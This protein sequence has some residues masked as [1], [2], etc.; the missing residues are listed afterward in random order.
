MARSVKVQ[1]EKKIERAPDGTW[2]GRGPPAD[3]LWGAGALLE[4]LRAIK[5]ALPDAGTRKPGAIMNVLSP[6]RMRPVYG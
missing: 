2:L 6:L 5:T 3:S 4:V 1:D